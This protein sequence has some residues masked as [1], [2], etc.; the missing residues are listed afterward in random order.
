M[1]VDPTAARVA[2][3]LDALALVLDS[4]TPERLARQ[5]PDGKW[6]AQEHLTHLARYQHLF[7]HDRIRRIVAEDVPAF[8]RYRAE[9]DPEWEV[10]RTRPL[11]EI[12]NT[13]TSERRELSNEMATWDAAVWNRRGTHPLLGT[14]TMRQWTEMFLT[15]EGHHLYIALIRSRAAA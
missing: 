15:H 10:W 3:A 9:N 6:S 11:G 4:M 7:R 1:I 8:A 14:L 2:S 12:I 5:T 13:L